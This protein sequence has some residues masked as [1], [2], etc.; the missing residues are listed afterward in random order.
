MYSDLRRLEGDEPIPGRLF[1]CLGGS[2]DVQGVGQGGLR[3]GGRG[4]PEKRLFPSLGFGKT[5]S[6]GTQGEFRNGNS[7]HT[8]R[9]LGKESG[10]RTRIVLGREAFLAYTLPTWSNGFFLSLTAG[11]TAVDS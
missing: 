7:A 8:V 5:F 11:T 9:L 6:F 10:G 1:K 4:K 2:W 3:W